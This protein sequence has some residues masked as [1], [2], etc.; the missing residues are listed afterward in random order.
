VAPPLACTVRGCG[1]PLLRQGQTYTCPRGHAYDVARSGYVNLLQPQDRKSAEPGDARDAVAARARL[2][3][4]GVGR[5]VVEAVVTRVAALAPAPGAVVADLGCGTGSALAA[6]AA[7]RE[8]AG[9]GLD[10]SAAAV[11]HAARRWPGLTWVVANADRTLPLLDSSVD[12][13]LSL[14][15]RRNP[16]EAARVL[17]PDGVLVTAVPAADDLKEL[18]AAVQGAAV[19]RDRVPGLVTDCAPW[20]TLVDHHPVIERQHLDRE[21]LQALLRATYRGGRQ[22]VAPRVEALD[23]LDVTLASELCVFRPTAPHAPRG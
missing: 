8:I 7:T 14:H 9:I 13:L 17:R 3:D 11:A 4:A 18:R 21:G 15:A 22:A 20:L 16:A 5:A 12:V 23:S 10:L 1:Q 19:P 2:E 6:L